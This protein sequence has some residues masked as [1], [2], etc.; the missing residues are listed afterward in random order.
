VKKL[1]VL[2]LSQYYPPESGSASMKMSELAEGLVDKGHSTTI[3]TGFPNYPKGKIFENYRRSFL[4]KEK[5]NGVKVIRVPLIVPK[6]R[7]SFIH[8]MLNHTSFMLTSIYGGLAAGKPDLIYYYS[9]PLF[10]GFSAWILGK[11][12][13][14]PTVVEINDLWPQAPIELGVLKS[15][16]FIKIAERFE[17]FVYKNTEH[18][19]FYSRTMR[20]QV[21]NKGVSRKKTEIHPLWIS[22]NEFAPVSKEKV[23][24]IRKKYKLDGKFSV[25]YAGLIGLPQGLDIIVEVADKLRDN[26]DIIFVLVGAGAEEE[27]IK[28]KSKKAGLESIKFIPLQPKQEIPSFLSSADV[29]FVHLNP[30]SFRKGTLPGKVLAYMSMGK[31]LLVAVEGETN[32][33]VN[34]SNCGLTAEPRNAIAIA[35]GIKRLYNKENMREKMGRNA[36]R[37]AIENFEKELLLNN[38]EKGF[39]EIAE[40]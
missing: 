30:A 8:R 38:L 21:I 22:T 10:L 23:N 40:D 11:I 14:V 5:I 18:L 28:E 29:L 15:K 24:R 35:E 32:D 13:R 36:R 26:K 37:Y 7:A 16:F 27:N 4:R 39:I 31:P 34:R 19:F 25:M 12:Y 33:L 17:K 9:P 20:N 1:R 2:L 3:V 6:V